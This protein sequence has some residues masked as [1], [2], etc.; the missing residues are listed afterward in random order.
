MAPLDRVQMIDGLRIITLDTSVPGHHYGEINDS[1][2]AWLA[3]ELDKKHPTARFWRCT[4]RRFPVSWT[5]PSRSSC[6]IRRLGSGAQGHHVRPFW[7][8][9]CT[10]PPAQPS[11]GFR[12]LSRRPRVTPRI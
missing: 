4:I 3:D 11:S 8:G 9:T 1:Q 12:C 6:A 7:P 10:I 5:W 2:L